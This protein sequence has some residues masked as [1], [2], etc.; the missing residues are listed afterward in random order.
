MYNILHAVRRSP[1]SLGV[2]LLAFFLEACVYDDFPDFES[3]PIPKNDCSP[4]FDAGYTDKVSYL[5]GE[6]IQVFLSGRQTI[7]LCRLTIYSVQG[8]SVFSIA[9]S[10]FRQPLPPDASVTGFNYSTSTEFRVPELKSGIYLIE[11]YIPFI[12]KSR[13]P[14]DVLVLYPSNTANAYCESGGLSLYSAKNRPFKVSFQRPIPLQEMSVSCLT[15]FTS[16]QNIKIGYIADSDME[17]FQNISQAKILTIAG[18]SE[19]WTR[20]ARLNFD[21]FVNEGGHAL[22]LSGNTMWW[23]VRYE[24]NQRKL[25]CYKSEDDPIDDPLMKTITWNQPSLQFPIV[26]SIGA[27]FQYGGYGL[28]PDAGWNGYKVVSPQSPLL[29]GLNL[30][31]G[32][33]ISLPTLEYDGAPLTGFDAEGIPIIDKDLLNFEKIELIAFDKGFRGQETVGTFILFKRNPNSGLIINTGSSNWCSGSGMG[34]TSGA[35]IKK[36][37]L[38][39]I[40]KLLLGAPVFSP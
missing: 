2:I 12:I 29:E 40:T 31:K 39:A 34:G 7:D 35:V 19:Y 6:Y 21:R 25:V 23:Q 20:Q 14:V 33:I 30:K 36:I 24:D 16:L 1:L 32:D 5:P 11:N 9:S 8:D 3:K 27:D 4:N 22:I 17:N 15:W 10:L 38:N 26:S 37:T 28:R 13:H 18:H